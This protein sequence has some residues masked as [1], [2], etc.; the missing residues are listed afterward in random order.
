MFNFRQEFAVVRRLSA[1]YDAVMKTLREMDREV[2]KVETPEG[3]VGYIATSIPVEALTAL[4]AK[5]EAKI[6]RRRQRRAGGAVN[7][8][9]P[10]S[11]TS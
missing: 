11:A 6:A 4:A 3:V 7:S 10:D 5:L 2:F 1:F 8:P 9:L